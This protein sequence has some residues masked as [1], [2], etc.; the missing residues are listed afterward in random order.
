MDLDN[1]YELGE[2]VAHDS[3]SKTFRARALAGGREVFVHILFGVPSA[4]GRDTL[5]NLLLQRAVDPSPEKRA[6]IIEVS[7]HKG[8]PY[9]VTQPLASF[10]GVRNWLEGHWPAQPAPVEPAPPPPPPAKPTPA[11]PAHDD[12]FMKLFGG[13]AQEPPAAPKPAP[14]AP[15]P[16]PPSPASQ[17]ADD[18]FAKLFGRVPSP[19]ETPKR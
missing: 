17:T 16:P 3:E 5:L 15:P 10:T 2:V 12:E 19:P 1:K 7:D 9:A 8:M 14:V 11:A 4:P 13:A 6:Q 18:E